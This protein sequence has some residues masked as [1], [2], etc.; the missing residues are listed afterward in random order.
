V[1]FQKRIYGTNDQGARMMLV[2]G[3]I[4]KPLGI[5]GLRA[6]KMTVGVRE[7]KEKRKRRGLTRAKRK[8]PIF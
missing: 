7:V 8:Q 4:I 6:T 2:S 1:F 3:P 5:S